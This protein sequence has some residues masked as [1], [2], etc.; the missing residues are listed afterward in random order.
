MAVAVKTHGIPFW[1]VGD[2]YF[3]NPKYSKGY[4]FTVGLCGNL[5][6][7][8]SPPI[9]EPT[10]VGDWDLHW[11]LVRDFGPWPHEENR[12]WGPGREEIWH[13][14]R[15]HPVHGN[16]LPVHGNEGMTHRNHS[17]FLL[18]FFWEAT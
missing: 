10:L 4:I 3:G 8:N 12:V 2:F 17:G 13:P 9:L 5:K 18:S 15:K 7:L 11:I 14:E 1:L 16:P 6:D